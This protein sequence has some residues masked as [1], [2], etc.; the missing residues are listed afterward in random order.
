MPT[1][2][3]LDT[4]FYL[5]P[6]TTTSPAP[7]DRCFQALAQAAK[8][9]TV[10]A[11]ISAV[12]LAGTGADGA[13][14]LTHIKAVGGL[15]A[16]QDPLDTEETGWPAQTLA[17]EEVDLVLPAAE[18]PAKVVEYTQH[19][20]QF[21]A[22]PADA[23]LPPALEQDLQQIVTAVKDQTG[24]DF[25]HYAPAW[26]LSRLERRM[27]LVGDSTLSQYAQRLLA[28][29]QE[30]HIL[31]R[32][33][34]NS[35]AHFFRP[36]QSFDLF[37]SEIIPRLFQ[38]KRTGEQVRIWVVGCATGE[39]VYS[40]TM[41]LL[42]YMAQLVEQPE[43]RI[44]ATDV[45]QEALRKAREGFYPETI[46]ADVPPA[47][48]A[49]FFDQEA[50][51]YRLR[52][53]VRDHV[54]F[55]EHNLLRDPPFIKLGL[56]VCRNLLSHF[57]P[58]MQ[59]RLYK[60]FHFLLQ[61][62]GYLWV[63]AAEGLADTDSFQMVQP[64][65][66][67]YRREPTA[68]STWP[69]PLIK[70]QPLLDI[71]AALPSSGPPAHAASYETIYAKQM[72]QYGP[73]GLLV[74][75]AHNIVYY[76][77][78]VAPYLYQPSGEATDQV[79]KR[80]QPPF[81]AALTTGLYCAFNKSKPFQSHLIAFPPET[82]QRQVHLRIEPVGNTDRPV[83][84]L[85][86]FLE[87]NPQSLRP[88]PQEITLAARVNEL[89][90]SLILQQ[91]QLVATAE[92]Y[93]ATKEEMMATQDELMALNE[94]LL[95][96][97]AE[98]EHSKAELQSVNKELLVINQENR[99]NI[100][101]LG[102]L[103][104]NLQNLMVATD[105]AT[106][107]LDRALR[108]RWLTP[109]VQEIFN[110][111]STDEGRPLAHITHHLEYPNLVR[112]A[113]HVLHT[114]LP[115]EYESGSRTGHWY[116]IRMLPYRTVEQTVDGVVLTFFDITARKQA[117]EALRKLNITLE[118]RV[119]ER[120]KELTRS[121]QELDQFAYIASHDLKAPLRAIH[122][123][124]IWI[125]E[126]AV[127][128]LPAE[129]KAHLDK[130]HGRVKRMGKLIDDL[131]AYSRAGRH[132]HRPEWVDTARL[133]DDLRF[134]LAPPPGFQI[135]ICGPLPKIY[136][137]RVPLE[138]VLRNLLDN[139]IKHHHQPERGVLQISAQAQAG[140][141]E[142]VL[143][144]NGPGIEPKYHERIFQVFQGLKP[145]EEVEGSGMG[146][147]VVKKAVE[148]RG[149]HVEIESD[150]GRGTTFRFTWPNLEGGRQ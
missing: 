73:P 119:E 30:A 26:L 71:S 144:D 145:R 65:S 133:V 75:A 117:E 88:A 94:E 127:D 6:L 116:F 28:K 126:D 134:F 100:A 135:E 95:M 86:L 15:T 44:F 41:L 138:T 32:D 91:E 68:L 29:S 2:F 51:G 49:R 107:F 23:P 19:P 92:E 82:G 47:Y 74:D 79:L 113:E 123:L 59:G 3:G 147:A 146:L 35:V 114:L 48:L 31:H 109:R 12:V 52:D 54:V 128:V 84:V 17:P 96:K 122:N 120:T 63:D 64:F 58:D 124:A 37:S 141:T 81:H 36:P 103:T 66:G 97:A 131:L 85:V 87:A 69:L 136:T 45:Q 70:Q 39:E 142:F 25:G 38:G 118:R 34:L 104:A 57:Q 9:R 99:K 137:E 50:N 62:H 4:H 106:L 148:T 115:H 61:P 143:S 10:D 1:E 149:G 90:N 27:R 112:D 18:L 76:S 89:E 46:G 20:P 67:L 105:I 77:T 53:E 5:A 101:D 42:D 16:M 43:L 102:Q 22:L 125:E 11:P 130:L 8:T 111:L 56:I 132:L 80:V 33:W 93:R 121:N 139:A 55:A 40:I 60:L 7:V 24:Q 108:V 110:L 140:W 78:G 21:T 98:L 72:E 83:F 14:G 13:L 150:V 129:T